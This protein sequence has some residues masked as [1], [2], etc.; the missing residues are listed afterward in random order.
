MSHPPHKNQNKYIQRFGNHTGI[1]TNLF[2][3]EGNLEMGGD[4]SVK[5]EKDRGTRVTARIPNNSKNNDNTL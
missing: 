5:S 2:I 4:V 1:N 3:G